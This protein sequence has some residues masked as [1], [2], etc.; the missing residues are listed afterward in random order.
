MSQLVENA[1]FQTKFGRKY[2]SFFVV[3]VVVAVVVS[4]FSISLSYVSGTYW[5]KSE[6]D[7]FYS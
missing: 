3:V 6:L 5:P 2:I 1:P 7:I 4:R